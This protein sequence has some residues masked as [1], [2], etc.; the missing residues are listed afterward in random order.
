MLGW[1]IGVLLQTIP[2][3]TLESV[4]ILI[5]LL[6]LLPTLF[7]IFMMASRRRLAAKIEDTLLPYDSSIVTRLVRFRSSAEEYLITG[8][9][10]DT[11][12]ETCLDDWQFKGL[13]KDEPWYVADQ[14]GNDISHMSLESYDG[15]C[16]VLLPLGYE[17]M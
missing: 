12:R 15:P 9:A 7:L 2:A 10:K 16:E 8:N 17:H 13:E 14:R 11:Y 5:L 3:L 4:V 6:T 1:M